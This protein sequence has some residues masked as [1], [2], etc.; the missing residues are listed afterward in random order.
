MS[1][2]HEL[3]KARVPHEQLTS[4]R[5]GEALHDLLDGLPPELY[6]RWVYFP[7]SGELVHV[8][9]PAEFRQVR[10]DRNRH[11]I[12][13]VDMDRLADF[14]VGIVG[15]SVGN[16]IAVSLAMEGVCHLRLA[17]AD[18]L[19][20]SNMN[21]VRAAVHDIGCAKTTLLARQIWEINPYASLELVPE[22]LTSTNVEAFLEGLD[23]VVEECDS[24][25]M[26][27][28]LREHARARRLPV[29]MATSDQGLF[30][31]ER[32]DLEPDRPLLHGFAG[33]VT[34]H[35]LAALEGQDPTTRERKAALVLELLE[36]DRISASLGA[37]LIEIDATVS[38]WPQLCGD[39]LLGA[40]SASQAVRTLASGSPLPSGRQ[41]VSLDPGSPDLPPCEPPEMKPALGLAHP[42]RT[43]EVSGFARE[44]VSYAVMAPSGGNDQPWHFYSDDD[45]LWVVHDRQRSANCLDGHHHA[46]MLTLGAATEN[47]TIAAAAHDVEAIVHTFPGGDIAAEIEF[48]PGGDRSLA[49]LLP[50]LSERHTNRASGSRQPLTIDSIDATMAAAR[51]PTEADYRSW[52]APPSSRPSPT[53]WAPSTASGFCVPP[54]IVT[55]SPRSAG[56]MPR[57]N[58]HTTASRCPRCP[59]SPEPPRHSA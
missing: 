57:R 18:Q 49:T 10:L 46:A 54:R 53:S 22:G 51:S 56:P 30:D 27:F 1:Q 41:R 2:L 28:A 14:H 5:I 58:G 21:R 15:L 37:S 39:V 20:L 34:S 33:D 19:E 25:I 43:D 29:L 12:T 32:F 17:D 7:W 47:I 52:T 9:P 3:V 4:D 11:K 31:V 6:G 44:M 42:T 26:K 36:A 50:L 16:A 55:C 38:T 23:V 35:D 45:R 59:S 24:L 40:A 13:D 48:A 8:L